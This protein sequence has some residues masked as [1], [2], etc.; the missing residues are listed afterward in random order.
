MVYGH[1]SRLSKG[2]SNVRDPIRRLRGAAIAVVA[3][4]MSAG[5]AF[6]AQP[7]STAN[8]LANAADHS[9]KTVPVAGQN[10]STDETT[11]ETDETTTE[12][13]ETTTETSESTSDNCSTDPTTLTAEQLAAMTHGSIVCWAAHQATPA[14]YANHGAW[15]SSWAHMGNNH[16][17]N[18]Q[19]HKPQAPSN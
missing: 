12:T 2:N 1:S 11:T 3:L 4:A 5:L 17:A 10:V 8:G 19:S 18:G 6:A 15:V 7:P 13:D 14:G 16:A 9:G